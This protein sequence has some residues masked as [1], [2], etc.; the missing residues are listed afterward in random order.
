MRP[1]GVILVDNVL[2]GGAIVDAADD[3]ENTVAIRAFN[4]LVAADDRVETRHAPARRRPHPAP[5][6]LTALPHEHLKVRVR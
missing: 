3:D 2:W 5:Q 1:N 6:A 4:D